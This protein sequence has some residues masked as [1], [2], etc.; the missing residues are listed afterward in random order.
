[1]LYVLLFQT[2][3]EDNGIEAKSKK[4]EFSQEAMGYHNK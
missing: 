2:K 1:M 4:I 3:K